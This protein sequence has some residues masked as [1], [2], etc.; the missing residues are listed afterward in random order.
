MRD[1]KMIFKKRLLSKNLIGLFIIAISIWALIGLTS[2]NNKKAANNGRRVFVYN[3]GEYIDPNLV[4]QFEAET[5]IEVIYSTFSTNEDLYVKFKNGGA[6]YDL[7]FP[8]EYMLDKMRK[9]DMLQ[10]LDYSKIPNAKY[11]DKT[12]MNPS[13]DPDQKYSL[14]YFWGTLGILYNKKMVKD[15]PQS[16]TDLWNADYAGNIIMMDSSRDSLGVGLLLEG[17]SMNSQNIKDLERARQRLVDQ[18]PLVYAY[19]IDQSKDI[20]INNECAMAMMYSGEALAAMWEN[21][22][23]DYVVPKEGSNIWLDLFA[24]PKGAEN[25]DEAHAFINFFLRPD[26]MAKN[27]EWV[28]YSIPSDEG[29]KLLPEDVRDNPVAYPDP[30]VHNRLES[31]NDPGKFIDVYNE[32]WQDVKNR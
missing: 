26:I 16:W 12:Y 30:Q 7:I 24:I 25:I 2:C 19:L 15:K 20:M 18:Y 8:S 1:K 9:E 23:L 32:Y 29:R 28:G 13:Y 4:K 22:D 17:K 3:W 14:P 6:K 27:A 21:E 11:V 5:G 10:A 31:Y